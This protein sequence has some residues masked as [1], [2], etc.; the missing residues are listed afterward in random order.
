MNEVEKEQLRM[1]IQHIF[2]SGANEIRV[3]EMVNIFIE[4][5]NGVNKLPIHDVVGQSEQLVCSC[6]TETQFRECTN[7]K[8]IRFVE[9]V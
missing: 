3:F 4:S 5:R 9:G 1:E 8:C 6:K 7:F 2:D